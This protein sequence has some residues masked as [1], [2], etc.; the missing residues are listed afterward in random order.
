MSGSAMAAYRTGGFFFL[1]SKMLGAAARLY[2]V[3]P[4]FAELRVR[5]LGGSVRGH[6]VRNGFPDLAIH[7]QGRH[8]IVGVDRRFCKLYVW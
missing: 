3:W 4:D 5:K 1:L 2:L 7:L 8:K 6:G